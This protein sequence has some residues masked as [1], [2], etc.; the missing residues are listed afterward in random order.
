MRGKKLLTLAGSICLILILAAMPFM[1]A[2]APEEA[3]PPPPPPPPP[4]EEEAPPPVEEVQPFLGLADVP[5]IENK[6]PVF[7]VLQGNVGEGVLAPYLD[8]FSAKTGVPIKY[9]EMIMSVLY[10]RVNVELV[11]GSGA[12]DIICIEASSTNE[13]AP[14]LYS[15]QELAKKYDPLGV[16]GLDE[17]MKGIHPAIYRCCCDKEGGLFGLPYYTYQQATFYRKDVFEDPTE[18]ADFK[19]KY[20]YELAPAETWDQVY[21]HGEFF[22]RKK[23]E[24]LKGEP[25]EQDVFGLTQMAGRYEIND[26]ISVRIWSK[27]GNWVTIERDEEG[28]AVSY[29]ITKEDKETLREVLTEYQECLQWCSPGCLTGFWDYCTAQMAAG[30]AMEDP[31]LYLPLDQWAFTI[32]DAIPGAVIAFAPS[33]GP[34]RGQG[35]IGTFNN[36]IVRITKNPEACYWLCRYLS[37]YEVQKELIEGGWSGIRMDVYE[38]PMY[39]K[40]EWDKLIGI[41]GRMLK[42]VWDMMEPYVNDIIHFNSDAMGKIYEQ[43]IIICHEAAT[44]I[45]TI[46]EGVRKMTDTTLELQRKFGTLPI[47]EEE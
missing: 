5:E 8:Q 43:Q 13:W 47:R 30:L 33:P 1:A 27:G 32:E 38:D 39:E 28:N 45:T 29:V 26:E 12:Y 18:K 11:S 46:D 22:T 17:D 44:G 34:V 40:P 20:G 6:A 31:H 41:R 23:G 25:L 4:P 10:P 15:F 9:E 3:P 24:L 7:V 19:A 36:G 2:C 35:Y 42:Q 37:S 21:D 14:Y 16:A